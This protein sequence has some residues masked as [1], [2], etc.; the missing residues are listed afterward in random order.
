M[1]RESRGQS[2]LMEFSPD[3]QVLASA[4][5]ATDPSIVQLL[6]GET[7]EELAALTPPESYTTTDL[8]F[9]PDGSLLAQITN[10]SGVV[11]LWDLRRIRAH[12]ATMGLDWT[13]TP[14]PRAQSESLGNV[15]V[16]VDGPLIP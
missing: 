5:G 11:H 9:S 6:D 4:G 8:A 14:Y 7:L 2:W 12:L 13:Q 3:G 16:V 10:R 1:K 15:S